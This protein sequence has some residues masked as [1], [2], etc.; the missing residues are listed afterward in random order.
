MPI[1]T[2]NVDRRC[3]VDEKLINRLF[4]L[5][6]Y[7]SLMH[8]D[9]HTNNMICAVKELYS[10]FMNDKYISQRIKAANEIPVVDYEFM[11][12][13]ARCAEEANERLQEFK[14][15]FIDELENLFKAKAESIDK[16]IEKMFGKEV[17]SNPAHINF[18]Q[19][20][21]SDI[22][23][24]HNEL[25]EK[26]RE[27][28]LEADIRLLYMTKLT[29]I[30][31]AQKD[32]AVNPISTKR[33]VSPSG[34][35]NSSSSGE[36]ISVTFKS[37]GGYFE[38]STERSTLG[39]GGQIK[40]I[41]DSK[42]DAPLPQPQP[43]PQPSTKAALSDKEFEDVVKNTQLS[44]PQEMQVEGLQEFSWVASLSRVDGDRYLLGGSDGKIGD[45]RIEGGKFTGQKR[46]DIGGMMVVEDSNRAV[47]NAVRV[48]QYT[49]AHRYD[50]PPLIFKDD[51][52]FWSSPTHK[53]RYLCTCILF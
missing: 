3:C 33:A 23:F 12:E 36:Y 45:G 17:A 31:D 13:L 50:Q 32:K 53:C 51:Q 21:L 20:R 30:I 7:P 35:D 27:E 34:D 6:V 4:K 39:Q 38:A 19:N 40:S 42:K 22:V 1:V 2:S 18:V 26:E 48:G 47:Y 29:A 9:H 8:M 28:G 44:Q 11:V 41:S 37:Q 14:I 5:T 52:Q 24:K 10:K 43:A 16:R 15:K 49:Y 25:A 46:I